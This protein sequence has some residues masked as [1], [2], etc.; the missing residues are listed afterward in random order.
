M[1]GKNP[2]LI[3]LFGVIA[4]AIVVI[5][6][7]FFSIGCCNRRRESNRHQG[8]QMN[9]EDHGPSSTSNSMA[10]LLPI[11]KYS[12]E[13]GEETCAV[14]LSEFKEG[15]EIRALPENACICFM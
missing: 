15:E 3:G 8:P 13:C 10:Q 2:I 6:Y 9:Q 5:T 4:G 14:C 12:K 11:F 7:H 1:D